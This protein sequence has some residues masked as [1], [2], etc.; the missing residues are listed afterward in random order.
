MAFSFAPPPMARH[1][2]DLAGLG[3]TIA[4][5]VSRALREDP[6]SRYELAGAVSALLGE[7]VSKCML[8]A[9]ASEAR[10]EHNVSAERW[11]AILAATARFD[12]LD[13]TLVRIGARALVGEEF[14]AARLGSLVAA[15]R[16]IDEQIRALSPVTKPI[17]RGGRG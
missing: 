10:D 3:R 14:H 12:I 15:K 17:H 9:Y 7:N 16:E 4:S 1:E 6:R 8:D 5:G 11:L 13:A 2:G